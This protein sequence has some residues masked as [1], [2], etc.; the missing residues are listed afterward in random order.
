MR[1]TTGHFGI[2]VLSAAVYAAGNLGLPDISLAAIFPESLIAPLLSIGGPVPE[3]EV[4]SLLIFIP[5]LIPVPFVAVLGFPAVLGI[6]LGHLVTTTISTIGAIDLISP[7]FTFI[8]LTVI[9]FLRKQPVIVG[10]LIYTAI[11]AAW[12]SVM[13]MVT[14]GLSFESTFPLAFIAQLTP[15]ILGVIAFTIIKGTNLFKSE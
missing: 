15:I 7:V 14:L 11:A 8:G 12:M 13:R 1:M 2:F 10:A 4:T 3:K 5:G 9:I 6:T